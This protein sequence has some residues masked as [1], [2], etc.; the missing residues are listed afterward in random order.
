MRQTKIGLI[1]VVTSLLAACGD[2]AAP[3][4]TAT[5]PENA[6]PAAAAKQQD[7]LA[8]MRALIHEF[9]PLPLADRQLYKDSMTPFTLVDLYH[10]LSP[11]EE[12]DVDVADSM[13]YSL[14][15]QGFPPNI[16]ELVSRYKSTID[17]FKMRDVAKELS[18]A[19]QSRN[20]APPDR[21]LRLDFTSAEFALDSYDFERKG[22]P[23][24]SSLLRPEPS[25]VP[26]SWATPN[27]NPY[28]Q[29]RP[30][31]Y[32]SIPPNAYNLGLDNAQGLAFLKVEDEAVARVIEAN[33]NNLKIAV[34]GSVVRV[35]R[36]YQFSATPPKP[37][38]NRYVIMQAQRVDLVDADGKL[39]FTSEL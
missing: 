29:P 28:A 8:E 39:V 36:D 22:F 31:T 3:D 10:A 4:K 20:I 6:Q 24:H 15:Y 13:G 1:L 18:A 19:V 14:D 38:A 33:R 27:L 34:Y 30:R 21:L 7:A 12:A 5:A 35:Y 16:I 32:V 37:Q 17:A 23:A 11:G 9:Q 2:S 26:S 25:D